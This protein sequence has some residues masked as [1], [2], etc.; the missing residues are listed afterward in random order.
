MTF[1]FSFDDDVVVEGLR[2]FPADKVEEEKSIIVFVASSALM[3]ISKRES[4]EEASIFAFRTNKMHEAEKFK[5][6]IFFFFFLITFLFDKRKNGWNHD[7]IY[8]WLLKFSFK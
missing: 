2:T 1:L 8:F 7:F 6:H 3:Q 4:I 5:G